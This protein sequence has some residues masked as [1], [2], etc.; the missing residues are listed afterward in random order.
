[1]DVSITV[2]KMLKAF[3]KRRMRGKTRSKL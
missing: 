1:M 3:F 2:L